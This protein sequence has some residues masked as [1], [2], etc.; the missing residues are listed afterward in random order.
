MP[1]PIIIEVTPGA[2]AVIAK[3][4]RFPQEIGQAIKRGMDDAGL[5]AQREIVAKRFR[6]ISKKPFPV[7]EHRLRNI[8]DRLQQSI[9]WKPATV[10]TTGSSVAVTGTMGSFGVKYFPWHEYGL[11]VAPRF[12]KSRAKNP[13]HLAIPVKG[14]SIPERAPMRTGIADHKINFQR[15]IQE[16]LEKTLNAKT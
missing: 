2:Q 12:R 4:R 8:S 1:A 5:T 9:F 14:Y 10:Q 15:K 16:E 3:L 7:S 13:K 11:T 6:G